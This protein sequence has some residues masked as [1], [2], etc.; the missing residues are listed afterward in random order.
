MHPLVTLKMCLSR[1]GSDLSRVVE[2]Q[3]HA[4]DVSSGRQRSFASFPLPGTERRGRRTS[5]V[6]RLLLQQVP[7]ASLSPSL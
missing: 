7:L 5:R 1:V 6:S 2:A 4:V 3:C